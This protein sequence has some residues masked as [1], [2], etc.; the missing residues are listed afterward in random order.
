MK[1]ARREAYDIL[2][3]ILKDSAYSNLSLEQALGVSDFSKRD[4]AFASRLVYGTL[5]RQLTLDYIISQFLNQPLSKLKK[6]VLVNLRMAVYQLYFMDK[7]PASAVI[8][9]AVNLSKETGCA[10]ASGL[11][12][13]VLRKIDAKRVN[14]ADTPDEIRYSC[15]EHLIRM[16]KKMYG[17]EN[18]AGILENINKAAPFYIRVNTLKTNQEALIKL[19][20]QEG[21]FAKET[22]FPNALKLENVGG[23]AQLASFQAGLFHV[24]DLASQLC[25]EALGAKPGET[26][27]DLCAAPGGK[28][29]TIAQSMK[30]E[31]RILAFDLYEH[32]LDLIQKTAETLGIINLETALGDASKFNRNLPQADRVLCDVPC[33]GLGIIRRKPEIRYKNLDSIKELPALQLAIL[34]NGSN[35][36]KP[37]GTLIY[38]TCALNKKENNQVAD[39]FLKKYPE[40]HAV[41]IFS[42]IPGSNMETTPYLTLF[43]H[44][45]GA[46]GF[47][48]A[49]FERS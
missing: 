1:T 34:E 11:I 40:F 27:F 35:Y 43:P 33:S 38:S 8:N 29:F 17:E 9:E 47:F 23:V 22:V 37:G 49:K 2:L 32:R 46:D 7:V 24:Q 20:E 4:R 30:N 19:L 42:E 13:A 18:T 36:V 10:F 21:I 12:N 48:I 31:G 26:V 44:I 5:E 3:H 6:Q 28:T 39:A 41:P 16:W 45:N 25:A 15:P 14:L